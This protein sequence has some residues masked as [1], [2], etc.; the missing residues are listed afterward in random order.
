MNEMQQSG[1]AGTVSAHQARPLP[2]VNVQGDPVK[3]RMTAIAHTQVS[4]TE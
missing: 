2:K 4:D 1:F 3:Q